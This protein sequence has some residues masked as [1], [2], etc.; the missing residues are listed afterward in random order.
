MML[1][2]VKVRE[3]SRLPDE[4]GSFA[5]IFRDDW[6][7]FIEGD[8]IVQANLSYSYPGMIRAWHRHHRGQVDYFITVKGATKICAYDDR[9]DSPT[10]NQ[11]DEIISSEQKIQC[12][13]IPGVYYHGFK[14]IGSKPALVVYL[15][16]KMYDYKNPDEERRSWNDPTI[17][18]PKT[19]KPFDWNAPPHK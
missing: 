12:V 9:K 8:K 2:G 10:K 4:R 15:T 7:D 18:D 13:R 17:I 14:S 11:L 16:T 5:E 1:P 6:A 3:I 19:K